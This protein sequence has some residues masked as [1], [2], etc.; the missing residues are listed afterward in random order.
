MIGLGHGPGLDSLPNH[1][2]ASCLTAME[3]QDSTAASVDEKGTIEG[4]TSK[5]VGADTKEAF[6]ATSIQM[7]IR[8]EQLSELSLPADNEIPSYATS[9]PSSSSRPLK[10]HALLEH[11]DFFLLPLLR[12]DLPVVRDALR[13][14]LKSFKPSMFPVANA[15]NKMVI[16]KLEERFVTMDELCFLFPVDYK[17]VVNHLAKHLGTYVHMS[18]GYLTLLLASMLVL[19]HPSIHPFIYM[20]VVM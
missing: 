1:P 4:E 14:Y 3:M 8:R 20:K 2:V 13:K 7:Q 17:D 16:N 10:A 9:A 19:V 12:T 18:L 11:I 15:E 6:Y 5:K